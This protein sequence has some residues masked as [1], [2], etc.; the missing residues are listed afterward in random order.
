MHVIR[1]EKINKTIK[2]KN[3]TQIRRI[4]K[5]KHELNLFYRL[6]FKIK[7]FIQT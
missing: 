4:L 7:Q 3:K 5:A 6:V 1:F 2:S